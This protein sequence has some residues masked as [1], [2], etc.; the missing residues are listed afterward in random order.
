MNK[1]I[2]I[3]L[4]AM[5]LI[6]IARSCDM[7]VGY[8]LPVV[9]DVYLNNPVI[10]FI[11][12]YR[13]VRSTAFL[14][15]NLAVLLLLGRFLLKKIRPGRGLASLYDAVLFI[16]FVHW[17]GLLMCYVPEPPEGTFL[18]KI[19]DA[20]WI[21]IGIFATEVPGWLSSEVFEHWLDWEKRDII[22]YRAWFTFATV[23]LVFI[24]YG[25]R[26][27]TDLRRRASSRP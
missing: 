17:S 26:R 7:T 13:P 19:A 15:V 27:L 5:C 1:K 20:F 9:E 22:L 3:V 21:F 14:F 18:Y 25:L 2:L 24:F 6:P 4:A 12:N 11:E 16:S 8:P 10:D 23:A